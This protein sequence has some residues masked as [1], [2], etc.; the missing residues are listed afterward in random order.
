MAKAAAEKELERQ[1]AQM[2]KLAAQQQAVKKSIDQMADEQRQASTGIHQSADELRKIADEMQQSI[3]DMKSNGVKPETVQRQERILSR[4]L[5]A[6]HSVHER[7]QD[8][9]RESKP[10][11]DVVRASPRDLNIAS[12][13]AQKELQEEILNAKENGFTPDYNA[14]ILTGTTDVPYH[15]LYWRDDASNGPG[16]L[17]TGMGLR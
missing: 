7:D 3:G 15:V 9:Q 12:P 5:Q 17:R 2:S 14:L 6:E 11:E 8:Q 13:Q 16:R 1:Q 4:L 10:G